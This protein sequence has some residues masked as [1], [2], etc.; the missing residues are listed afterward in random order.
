MI[1]HILDMIASSR[2]DGRL[3]FKVE[4]AEKIDSKI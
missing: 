2:S 1:Y 4:L 3:V